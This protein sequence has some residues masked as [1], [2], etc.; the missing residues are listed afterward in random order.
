MTRPT[1]LRALITAV[2][3]VIGLFILFRESGHL[4]SNDFTTYWAASRILVTGGNPYSPL[5]LLAVEKQGGLSQ[6]QPTLIY[7]P[8]WTLAMISPFGL[9]DRQIAQE[10]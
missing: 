3:L 10:G 6:Q 7:N 1:L 9:T 2:V 8:P 5:E 4:K